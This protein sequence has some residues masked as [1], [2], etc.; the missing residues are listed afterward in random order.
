[1][2]N[3]NGYLNLKKQKDGQIPTVQLAQKME[4][5]KAMQELPDSVMVEI[6]PKRMRKRATAILNRLKTRPDVIMWDKSREVK[7]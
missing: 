5:K 6:V 7:L 4:E 1:M 3:W 2:P